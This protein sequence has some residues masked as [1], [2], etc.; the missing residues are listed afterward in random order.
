MSAPNL[1]SSSCS[2]SLLLDAGSY[3]LSIS[4]FLPSPARAKSSRP[5]SFAPLI[6]LFPSISLSSPLALSSLSTLL[7]LT[8]FRPRIDFAFVLARREEYSAAKED[9][10]DD[11]AA[12]PTPE[13]FFFFE[14]EDWARWA[15]DEEDFFLRDIA[16]GWRGGRGGDGKGKRGRR[17]GFSLAMKEERGFWGRSRRVCYENN[18]GWCVEEKRDHPR[19]LGGSS[20][21]LL[22]L[23]K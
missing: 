8:S 6:T 1:F 2:S 11:A 18:A 20:L 15:L 9:D 13:D 19:K 22:K 21:R 14:D 7:I 12:A 16:L 10:D 17:D 3:P 5:L 4:T 23:Y